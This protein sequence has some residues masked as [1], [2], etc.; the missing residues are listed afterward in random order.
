MF[1]VVHILNYFC[2]SFVAPGNVTIAYELIGTENR[3]LAGVVQNVDSGSLNLITDGFDIV[4]F[5]NTTVYN[6][7]WT[8]VNEMDIVGDYVINAEVRNTC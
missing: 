4:V 5:S 2:I 1:K 7:S 8:P 3:T 6:L